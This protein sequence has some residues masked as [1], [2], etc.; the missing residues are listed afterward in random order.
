MKRPFRS[1]LVV[2]A[3]LAGALTTLPT[4]RAAAQEEQNLDEVV[5]YQAWYQ[6]NAAGDAGKA[7]TLASTYLR[8]YP[9]GQYA[10]YLKKWLGGVEG[11]LF[12][13]AIKAKDTSKIVS[14]GKQ[15]LATTPK[16]L[17]Y[18]Y[19]LALNLR[20]LELFAS[21]RNYSHAKDLA[22]FSRQAIAQIEAGKVPAGI[23]AAKWNKNANLAWLHQNLAVIAEHDGNAAQALTEYDKALTLDPKSPAVAVPASLACGN[24]RMARYNAAAQKF[25]A[26]PE[27]DR[28]AAEPGPAVKSALDA[29]NREADGAI[30]CWARFM[31]LTD[32]KASFAGVRGKIEPSL[33]GLWES[34][35]PGDAAGLQAEI[36]KYK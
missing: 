22:N 18:L 7:A 34:R 17:N 36:Q 15:H 23:P 24:L 27:A 21:P 26:I 31:A 4:S 16:D 9:K 8:K 30:E 29:I 19:S 6:A 25:N 35:H 20:K 28:Q 12:N 32:G 2:V 1:S 3:A 14:L 33:K 13:Q 5:A 11:A 10:A